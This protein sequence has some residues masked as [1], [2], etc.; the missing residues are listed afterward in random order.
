MSKKDYKRI[1]RALKIWRPCEETEQRL[2]LS[3]A[4]QI[5]AELQEDNPRFSRDLFYKACDA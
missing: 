3:I 1:A 5:A 2:W 4:E